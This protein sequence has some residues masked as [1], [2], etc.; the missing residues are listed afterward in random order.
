MEG[1]A[2]RIWGTNGKYVDVKPK[3]GRVLIFQHQGILHSGEE[4][5]KGVKYT[6]RS[7]FLYRVVRKQ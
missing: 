5:K 1:G 4:V 2:T 3:K 7:D 6:L